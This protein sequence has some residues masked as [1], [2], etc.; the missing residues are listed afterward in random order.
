MGRLTI[1]DISALV[2]PYTAG[3]AKKN[4]YSELRELEALKVYGLPCAGIREVIERTFCR[5]TQMNPVV[6]VFDSKSQKKDLGAG[7]KA[8]RK[9]NPD[10]G[11]QCDILLDVAERLGIPHFKRSGYEAD[12]FIYK[13]VAENMQENSIEILTG[14][15]QDLS[16]VIRSPQI[17]IVGVKA[18][19]P[20]ITKENY[21]W[22][23]KKGVLIEYNSLLPF[24]VFFGKA[25]NNVGVL[26]L[27]SKTSPDY[28]YLMFM[29]W[30]KTKELNGVL[31]PD[32]LYSE[33][34]VL[35]A[36]LEAM[37]SE[38]KI[39]KEDA[40]GIR[41]RANLIYPL[42]PPDDCKISFYDVRN[43]NQHELLNVIRMLHLIDVGKL[44]G[45]AEQLQGDIEP[46]PADK[47]YLVSMKGKYTSGVHAVD[48]DLAMETDAHD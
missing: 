48:N 24:N 12:D 37:I 45:F 28:M 4:A 34:V 9:F 14:D 22:A 1:I 36:W 3:H 5:L 8:T 27:P 13:L 32:Y 16:A 43:L 25:S 30:V 21:S 31:I 10:V 39:S 33:R 6:W 20:T 2:W 11:I 15:F 19:S 41:E 35:E 26:H 40:Q 7:Y 47:R 42:T 46:T 29:N 38:D 17:S 23:I 44:L 18:D